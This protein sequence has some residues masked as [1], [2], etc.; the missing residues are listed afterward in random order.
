MAIDSIKQL[1]ETL[2]SEYGFSYDFDYV[3]E[4]YIEHFDTYTNQTIW[5][6]VDGHYDLNVDVNNFDE[7]T[8]DVILDKVS[9]VV[10]NNNTTGISIFVRET[11]K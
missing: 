8:K 6:K 5:V 3:D 2:A 7:T 9:C 11:S 10:H 4:Q 1:V